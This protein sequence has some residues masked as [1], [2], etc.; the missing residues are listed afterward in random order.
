MALDII[1]E[2]NT[3]KKILDVDHYFSISVN[4]ENTDYIVRVYDYTESLEGEI[5]IKQLSDNLEEIY[6]YDK[7]GLISNK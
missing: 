3:I 5:Y 6:Y 7:T 4:V 1:N 2:I